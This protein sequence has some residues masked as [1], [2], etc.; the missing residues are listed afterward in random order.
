MEKKPRV[1]IVG[2]NQPKMVSNSIPTPMPRSQSTTGLSSLSK[3]LIEHGEHIESIDNM[4]NH[5]QEVVQ[6]YEAEIKTLQ[7]QAKVQ[8]VLLNK[9]DE[10]FLQHEKALFEAKGEIKK[11]VSEIDS[12]WNSWINFLNYLYRWQLNYMD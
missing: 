7:D 1:I 12:I 3:G 6:K 8:T 2:E 4:L 5:M 9:Q 10:L 11:L